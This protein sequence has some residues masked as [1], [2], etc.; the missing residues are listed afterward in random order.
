MNR[1]IKRWYYWLV[2]KC[3]RYKCPIKYRT[4]SGVIKY[5]NEEAY[6][7]GNAYERLEFEGNML[8]DE[9]VAELWDLVCGMG[10]PTAF[11]NANAFIGVGNGT[12]AAAQ[13]QTGL[14]GPTKTYQAMDV[15]YPTRTFSGNDGRTV[16][17]QAV[18]GSGAGNHR[19]EEW[20]VANGNSDTAKNLNR[21]AVF[22]GEKV[23]PAVWTYYVDI[24][25]LVT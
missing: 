19:W 9:G 2:R 7:A 11:S 1:W 6:L 23:S 16:R 12:T 8:L 22:I 17:F 15:G 18:F 25:L 5:A 10:T 14:I 13:N 24:T 4:R 20:T 3:F 21:K